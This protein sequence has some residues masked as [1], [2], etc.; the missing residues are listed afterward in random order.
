MNSDINESSLEP[1]ASSKH[2]GAAQQPGWAEIGVGLAVVAVVGFGGG[3]LLANLGLDPVVLGLIFTA[4][5]G[6]AALAGFAA[7]VLLRIRSLPAFGIRRTS[8]RWLLIGTGLGVVAFFSKVVV[9]AIILALS[10]VATDTQ[11]IYGVGASGGLWT[12][13]LA[14]LFLG[15]LTPIGEEF[16]FRGVITSALLRYGAFTGVVGGAFIFALMHG[17][18]IVFPVA[19]IGG[20]F[21]GEVFRRSGSVWPAVMVHVILNLPTIP[22]MALAGMGQV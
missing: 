9:L 20:L 5:S 6:I 1:S 22:L 11:D 21:A 15:V 13:I 14:T 12:V 3:G 10:D 16:L 4:L 19:V 7:A 2:H 18:N 8:L 17:V